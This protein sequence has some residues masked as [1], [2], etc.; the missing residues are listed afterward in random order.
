M[1]MQLVCRLAASERRVLCPEVGH[2][3]LRVCQAVPT[4]CQVAERVVAMMDEVNMGQVSVKG[5]PMHGLSICGAVGL[6][7]LR[8]VG[9]A[10]RHLG[11]GEHRGPWEVGQGASHLAAPPAALPYLQAC[12]V[13]HSYGTFVAS[14]LV[15]AH[16]PRAVG[17]LALIDPVCFGGYGMAAMPLC[18]TWVSPLPAFHA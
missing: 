7:L 14:R 16:G 3:S 4:A 15:Q 1:H 11:L 12:V 10:H 18:S 6:W 8:R 13:A 9:H 17:S 2:V 5:L